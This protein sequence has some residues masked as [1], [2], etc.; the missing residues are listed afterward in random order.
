MYFIL[1][2]DILVPEVRDK[3]RGRVASIILNSFINSQQKIDAIEELVKDSI[4]VENFHVE[5]Y[6]KELRERGVK[7]TEG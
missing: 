1:E 4:Y 5:N 7:L 2:E 3:F 6:K